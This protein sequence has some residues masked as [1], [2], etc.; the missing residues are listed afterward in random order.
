MEKRPKASK[1]LLAGI[2]LL[3]LLGLVS[4]SALV[5]YNS[6][7]SNVSVT[8]AFQGFT[9]SRTSGLSQTLTLTP[10]TGCNGKVTPAL[11]EGPFYKAGTPERKSLLEPG[12]TG[13]RLIVT[14]YVFTKNCKPI[15][16]AWL[17]FSHADANGNYDNAGYKLR[18]HQYTDESGRYQLETIVPGEYPG[19]TPHIHIK[20]Q[21]PNQSILTTQLFF[22]GQPRNPSDSIFNEALVMNIEYT[23]NGLVATFNFVIDFE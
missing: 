8:T 18:G 7:L 3:V 2:G 4:L 11:T 14:G 20:V 5:F 16:H 22:S 9:S 6:P 10:T 13:T 23:T 1:Y 15:A 12:I 21:A 17:D 19:R